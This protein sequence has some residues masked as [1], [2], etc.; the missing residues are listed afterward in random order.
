MT[1]LDLVEKHQ[2]DVA[3][4]FPGRWIGGVSMVVAPL[5]VLVGILLRFQ[6]HFFFPQQLAAFQEHPNLMTT[7]YNCFLAG[8]IALWPAIASLAALIGESRPGWAL[9]GATFAMFGLFARTFHAGADHMAFQ[10]VRV[11]DL[12]AAT[13]IVGASYGAF[14][15]VAS[16]NGA[17]LF[18][19]IILAVGAYL[20]GTLGLLRSVAL[21]LMSAL[22]MGVLKGSSLTSVVAAGGLCVALVP[23]GIKILRMPPRPSLRK[24]LGWTSLAVGLLA[25]LFFLG[26]QG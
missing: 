7:A 15:V 11:L 21:G 9:W 5:L 17:I 8:I 13:R 24:V 2:S 3:A 20:S 16:L 22:M 18:G 1:S 10:M 25:A 26:E 4:C 14:H 6:F 19:W 12:P 23:L